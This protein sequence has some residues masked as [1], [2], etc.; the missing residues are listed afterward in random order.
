[1]SASVNVSPGAI[2]TNGFTFQPLPSSRAQPD[3]LATLRLSL[4]ATGSASAP[5]LRAP[6][7]FSGLIERERASERRQSD[8]M[9]AVRPLN[10]PAMHPVASATPTDMINFVI[11]NNLSFT[12]FKN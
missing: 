2:L 1:M 5:A 11:Y 7:K 8:A 12:F 6:V 10:V 9:S 3:A 4:S